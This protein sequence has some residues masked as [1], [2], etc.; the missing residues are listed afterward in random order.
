MAELDTQRWNELAG[1]DYPF[2]RYEFL[3]ALEQSGT[4]NSQTGWQ[5]QHLLVTDN[6]ELLAI[7]PMYLKSHS[8]GEYVFD[9]AWAQ[10]YQ[11]HGLKYYPKLL[12]AIPFTPCQGPRLWCKPGVESGAIVDVLLQTIEQLADQQ[13][14]SSWH[15]LFPEPQLREQLQARDLIIRED[16]Q[17]QWFNRGYQQFD[18]FLATLTA[19]KRKMIKRERRKVMEQGISLQQVMGKAI[20]H[21][22]WQ[23]FYRFYALTYLKRRS[24]PYLNLAFF[25]Q[26]AASM[27]EHLLL[28]LAVKHDQPVAASLFF[29]GSDTLYGRYWGCDQDYDALHFEACYYQ[30]I[31]YC[32]A[33]NMQR[34]DSGAQGEH[35]IARGF[36]PVSRYSVHWIRDQ[37]FAQAI[38]DFVKRERAHISHYKLNA[39]ELLPFK[40]TIDLPGD[41]TGSG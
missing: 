40:H 23:V 18:E 27:P 22:H 38:A 24:Q 21:D 33:N 39:A 28:M 15:C 26:L 32:I 8:W 5:A 34:F 11:Q 25:Q 17:F 7:M 41:V 12:S 13:N 35:K 31:E 10:A 36:E 9:Q 1:T 4:V 14:L 20:T 2:L 37:R 6:D 30:G 19:S 3:N 29:V 16:V